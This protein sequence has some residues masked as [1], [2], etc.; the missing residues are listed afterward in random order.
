MHK[1]PILP[2]LL[3]ICMFLCVERICA[4]D[5]ELILRKT[6]IRVDRGRLAQTDTFLIQ[7]NNRNG[8]K[9]TQISIS[10]SAREKPSQIRGRIED[11]E[12]RVIR[13]LKNQDIVRVNIS[14]ESSLYSDDFEAT[15][16]LKHNVYPYRIR[17]SYSTTSQNYLMIADWSPVIGLDVPIRDACLQMYAP[18]GFLFRTHEQ[19]AGIAVTDTVGNLIRNTWHVTYDGS[20]QKELFSRSLDEIMP[21]VKLV[22]DVF[23]Y[24]VRG[25]T[26][27]WKDFGKWQ[28]DLLQGLGTLP[29]MEAAQVRNLVSGCK[30]T[31]EK[32]KTLYHYLQDHTRYINVSIDIGGMKPYPAEYVATNKYGDCKALTNYMKALLDAAGIPSFYTLTY[33][34]ENPVPVISDLPCQQFNHALLCVPVDGDTLWLEN[35]DNTNPFGYLD[36]TDQNRTA[37]LVDNDRSRLLKLPA[38][39]EASVLE[40]GITTYFLAKEGN[41]NVTFSHTYRGEDFDLLNAVANVLNRSDQ[42]EFIRKNLPVRG[43]EPDS[44]QLLKEGRDSRQIRLEAACTIPSMLKPLGNAGSF[45]FSIQSLPLP[46]FENPKD[47]TQDVRLPYPVACS[48]TLV[49]VLPPGFAKADLPD[50]ISLINHFGEFA[51]TYALN[52][53]RITIIRR[54]LLFSGSYKTEEYPAFYAFLNKVKT[55]DRRNIQIQ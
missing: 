23:E 39:N 41:T 29:A 3:V 48:D 33:R 52:A 8:E 2:Y 5:A 37:L 55:Y 35:T 47:R 44:W 30:S 14:S 51:V 54:F 4:A 11:L 53:G 25:S 16:T 28:A 9:Y 49:Y 20:I 6:E 50:S 24:G 13:E 43:A 7:I 17:Y 36:V 46:A 27:S 32:V 40:T 1:L 19:V 45:F 31:T 38:L 18:P 21:N 26:S 42:N 12:G 10:Y 15:F 22:P 34:D